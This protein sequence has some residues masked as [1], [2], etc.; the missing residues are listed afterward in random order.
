[1]F[2][3]RRQPESHLL[4]E[5]QA[6]FQE[7][8]IPPP[9]AAISGPA[10]KLLSMLGISPEQMAQTAAEV[11]AMVTDFQQRLERIEAKVDLMLTDAEKK[12]FAAWYAAKQ[13]ETNGHDRT[14]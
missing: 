6:Q 8:Q 1:M 3:R 9:P 10:A 14:G 5:A 4:L 12:R 7:D 2:A 13:Q 11:K